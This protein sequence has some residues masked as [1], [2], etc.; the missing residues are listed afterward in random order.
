MPSWT[1]MLG[2][3]SR[4]GEEALGGPWGLEALQAPLPLARRLMRVLGAVVHVPGLAGFHAGKPVAWG[5]AIAV[6]LVRDEHPGHVRQ[7]LEP[8]A[9][10]RLRRLRVA[11]TWYKHIQGVPIL[12][13][14]PPQIMPSAVDGEEDLIHVPRVAGSGTPAP[15]LLGRGLS[16]LQTPLPNGL[17]GHDNPTGEQARLHIAIAQAKAAVKPDAMADELCRETVA[18]IAA[19]GWCAH[20]P[21][22]APW[23]D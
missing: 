18:L 19:R 20:R 16:A 1:A 6:E 11:M 10:A 14:R 3:G 9:E 8:L 13:D 23:V 21:N 7:P 4:R 12:I 22:M 17:V 15:E 5:S 2:H